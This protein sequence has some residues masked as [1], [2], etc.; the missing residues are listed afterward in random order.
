MM[1]M[2]DDSMPPMVHCNNAEIHVMQKMFAPT[3]GRQSPRWCPT[4]RAVP[5]MTT[6]AAGSAEMTP[7]PKMNVYNADHS[8]PH[9]QQNSATAHASVF[10]SRS[11]S[12][13][14]GRYA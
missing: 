8:V 12:L 2:P 11:S 13:S 10:R 14:S 3:A 4:T 7:Q 5:T 9:T 6:N 1:T